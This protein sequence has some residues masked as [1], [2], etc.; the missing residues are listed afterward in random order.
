MDSFFLPLVAAALA[1]WGDKTQLL[2]LLLAAHYRRPGTVLAAVV[3]AAAVNASLAA[4][5]GHLLGGFMDDRA[6]QLFMAVAFTLAAVGALLPY[7]EPEGGIGWKRVGAF[8]PSF[9]GF[10]A[11]EFGDKTQFVTAALAALLPVWP[12]VAAGA[13]I[14]TAIGCAPAIMMADRFRETLP[15]PQIRR[16]VG[17]LFLLVAAILSINAFR[18]I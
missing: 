13:A 2:A 11:L 5:G 3:C 17:A 16:A 6:G 9:I 7:E 4:F 8:V 1:E 18:L 12:F 14:G 15:L 10:L